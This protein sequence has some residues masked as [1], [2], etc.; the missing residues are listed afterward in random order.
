MFVGARH[1]PRG[2]G[3]QR[4]ARQ[5]TAGPVTRRPRQAPPLQALDA[6][7]AAQRALFGTSPV[8]AVEA[9][10]S[11]A[12]RRVR[13]RVGAVF[14]DLP[15]VVAGERGVTHTKTG[16]TFVDLDMT[17]PGGGPGRRYLVGCGMAHGGALSPGQPVTVITGVCLFGT[18]AATGRCG[19]H[20][21]PLTDPGADLRGPA[22]DVTFNERL[23][24]YEAESL[25]R[26]TSFIGDL[27]RQLG[28]GTPVH[29]RA[30]IP[31]PEY[32]AH[33]LSL[34]ARGWLDAGA[35]CSYR[36]AVRR[37]GR[38][39][40]GLLRDSL[41][42][43]CQVTAGSPMDW[44]GSTDTWGT[45][46]AGLATLL[47]GTARRQ[48]RLWHDLLAGAAPPSFEA[49]AFASYTHHYLA[50]ARQAERQ[51]A[52]LVA[53]E[54]P[55]EAAIYRASLRAQHVTGVSMAGTVG[56][57]LHPRVVV[58][59]TAFASPGHWLYNCA[60]GCQPATLSLLP[61]TSQRRNAGPATLVPCRETPGMDGQERQ[62]KVATADTAH[63][64]GGQPGD[65]GAPLDALIKYATAVL[66][67][68]DLDELVHDAASATASGVNND[69]VEAQV[70]FLV[71]AIGAS[72]VL[73]EVARLLGCACK[74]VGH[75]TNCP[76]RALD[77]LAAGLDGASPAPGQGTQRAAR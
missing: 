2:S 61:L 27:A 17:A 23:H 40:A 20:T 65:T 9:P 76:A 70:R 74:G 13:A 30:H 35:L 18:D 5:G 39:L 36:L 57:Y 68:D 21:F 25:A 52:Q 7:L 4:L 73:E 66:A 43:T 10:S 42:G 46:P 15:G 22:E 37:R 54:N 34:Y 31:V 44:L 12:L 29:V 28:P 50:A 69:G 26:L 1:L 41:R 71:Q 45:A 47:A 6:A 67:E 8:A 60:D 72:A 16:L 51:G 14:Q 49:L 55:D 59:R 62:A 32:E 63:G 53:V 24:V 64:D 19:A 58:T 48:G 33:G 75:L 56:L 77:G 11:A 3:G 38:R